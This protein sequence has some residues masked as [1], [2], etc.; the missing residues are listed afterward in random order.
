MFY[1]NKFYEMSIGEK[2][3]ILSLKNSG[4]EMLS[5]DAKGMPLFVICLN[6]REGNQIRLSSNDAVYS[7]KQGAEEMEMTFAS[8]G[9]MDVFVTVNMQ[10]PKESPLTYWNL[11]YE[12]KT[13]MI[14]EW[15]DFPNVVVQN[16]LK[17][18]GGEHV[19]FWPGT[20]GGL[21]EDVDLRE[22][23]LYIKYREAGYMTDGGWTGVYPSNVNMQFM[24]Y[25]GEEDEKGL[26]VAAHDPY[27]NLKQIDFHKIEEGVRLEN[28][29]FPGTV[30]TNYKMPYDI[31]LGAFDGDWYD[32]ADI[33]RNWYETCE[34][35]KRP[36]KIAE[37]PELPSWY[38]A[39]PV[40]L[41]YAVRGSKDTGDMEP[42]GMFPYINGAKVVDRYADLLDSKVMAILM[43]W[44]GTAP[45]APPYVWPPFGG[46]EVFKEYVDYL[47]AKGN[48]IGVYGSGIGWTKYSYLNPDYNEE[49]N[50]RYEEEHIED[51]VCKT[52]KGTVEQ[53][54]VVGPPI[55]SGID[56]CSH[57]EQIK[58]MVR[59]EIKSLA[60]ANC[61]YVQY[62]DQNLGGLGP[63][64]Y[65]DKHGHAPVPGKWQTDD[66]ID[67][68]EKLL[69]DIKMYGSKMVLGCEVAASEPFIGQLLFN[70][71]RYTH[72]HYYGKT[73][74]AYGFLYHEYLNNFMGNNCGAS[75]LNCKDNPKNLAFRIANAFVSGNMLSIVLTHDGQVSWGWCNPNNDVLPNGEEAITLTRNLNA[76]RTGC[77]KSYLYT[78]KMLKPCKLRNVGSFDLLRIDGTSTDYPTILTTKW[79]DP[80][81]KEAQI[82]VNYLDE[83]QNFEI[84]YDKDAILYL[85]PDGAN[86]KVLKKGEKIEIA[87]FSAVLLEF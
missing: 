19:I 55:R 80:Q 27:G 28:R 57:N 81:G 56:I 29:L 16:N 79:R 2:G 58:N 36:K 44:E 38:E 62:F 65:S 21:I 7:V 11:K 63:M 72:Q 52:R 86:K 42:N 33:Y 82:F 43:H 60:Q 77:G 24:A 45:W 46:E 69:S 13:G 8:V 37:N 47:H 26:Y 84:V 53:S 12:N 54:R 3:S 41:I 18:T 76:W 71:S 61:D 78:G 22:K 17:S 87:P 35:M 66:M 15:V 34:E 49:S 23:W 73:V 68:Y 59:G 50:R 1:E 74:P 25:Y 4:K 75:S 9:G 14:V 48:Y 83:K 31:V 10:A 32:A 5:G 64:C 85:T 67:L 70:D 51:I 30:E 40:S 6:D 20:E 39:S